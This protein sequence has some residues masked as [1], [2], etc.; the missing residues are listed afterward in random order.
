M[1]LLYPFRKVLLC[2]LFS[3]GM[4]AELTV[5]QQTTIAPADLS[6]QP[7]VGQVSPYHPPAS[8]QDQ[9][10]NGLRLLVVADHRF[11]LVSIRLA[12]HAG[13]ALV[14]PAD[15]GLAGAVAALL[16]AG[17]ATRS[18]LQIAQEADRYGGAIAATAAP[19][20]LTVSTSGLANHVTPMFQLLSQ[21][22]LHPTFPEE[23]VALYKQ[24]ALQ[25]LM[26]ERAQPGF[27]AGVQFNK[28]LY[29]DNPYAVTAPTEESIGSISRTTLHRFHDRT[30]LPNNDAV[31]VVVGDVR[32]SVIRDLAQRYFGDTWKFGQL[33]QAPFLAP[34][35]PA[36]RHIFIVDRPGSAQ[37]TILLGNLGITRDAP[38]YFPLLV[39]NEV[40][41][42]SFNSRLVADIREQRGYAYGIGSANRPQLK[43]GSWFVSTE[44]RTAVTSEALKE[45]LRQLDALR[46]GA[47]TA[48]ELDQAKNYLA[49]S[50][51]RNLET[52]AQVADQFLMTALYHLPP[53]YLETYVSRVLAVT[54]AEAQ[55]AARRHVRPSTATIVIVG[56]AR[57]IELGLVNLQPGS[58]LTIF[59]DK[60]EQ[61][62]MF[63]PSG[64]GKK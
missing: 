35:V 36:A 1:T 10:P 58:M 16:T 20:Y 55:E 22:V 44:V 61:V 60:G 28:L 26:A 42:G 29:G 11:P 51:I 17:T 46:E 47:I 21:V 24:N 32:V 18:S 34:P 48:T 23:E 6:A 52:Q 50:F 53:N 4:L 56:D 12:V 15:A 40:L 57:Q 31:L 7:A 19:D 45:I 8:V 27:L 39:A 64:V 59:N 43:L 13:N 63:P 14:P 62:G 38:D 37:S 54:A 3:L 9:L 49:G 5:A 41:G 33:P 30:F 25:E 2:S